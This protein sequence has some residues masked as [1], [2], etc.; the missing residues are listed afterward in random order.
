MMFTFFCHETNHHQLLPLTVKFQLLLIGTG[1]IVRFEPTLGSGR[2]LRKGVATQIPTKLMNLCA[3][4]AYEK[5]SM[6]VCE[7]MHRMITSDVISYPPIQELRLEDY[8]ENRK[9][10]LTTP[11]PATPSPFG[12]FTTMVAA[13]DYNIF[14]WKCSQQPRVVLDCIISIR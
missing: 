12:V 11:F 7:T 1:T 13:P 5:K 6:E 4:P 2:E 10:P 8:T 9:L 14:I 3:M